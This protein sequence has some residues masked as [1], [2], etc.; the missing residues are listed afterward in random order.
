MSKLSDQSKQSELIKYLEITLA[1][2][3]YSI[4]SKEMH[5][6]TADFSSKKYFE[7]FKK[8]VKKAYEQGKL[9]TLKQWFRDLTEVYRETE[10]L[11]FNDFIQDKTGYEINIHERFDK[12]ISKIIARQK[13]KTA[14]EYRDILSKLDYLTQVENPNEELI[15][16]LNILLIEFK[17]RKNN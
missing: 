17:K 4:L 7:N 14:N 13:I 10:D 2:L 6:E 1:T 15:E 8:H 9:T 5:I 12:R 3:D 16:K 11:K